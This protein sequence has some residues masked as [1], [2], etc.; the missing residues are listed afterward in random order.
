MHRI[1]TRLVSTVLAL[2]SVATSSVLAL[3]PAADAR[4]QGKPI[5][6]YT[7]KKIVTMD[8]GWPEG[9]CVAVQ[10]GKI[11]SVGRTMDD[12]KPWLDAKGAGKVDIDETFR[13]EVLVPGFIEAHGHPLMGGMLYRMPLLAYLPTMNPYG[14]EIPGITTMDAVNKTIKD[15]LAT[16][17]DKTQTVIFWG[18][19]V[20][21][22]GR[23]LTAADLDAVTGDIPVMVWD[24]SEHFVYANTAAMKKAGVTADALKINGVQAGA[25]GKPNGQFLGVTAGTFILIPQLA[26]LMAPDPAQAA[27][28]HLM[29]MGWKN[30]VTTTSELA[31][32]TLGV[33]SGIASFERFFNDPAVP[34]RCVVVSDAVS[35]LAEKK[36]GAIEF[37]KSL[38][39]RSTDKLIY[40]GVKFFADDAF[41][42]LGMQMVNPG[43][44]DR[45]QGLWITQPGKPLVDSYRPWW[46]AGL[47]LHTHANGNAGNQAVVDALA[48]LQ[49]IKPRFDH[50]FTIQHYG[51]STPEQSRRLAALGGMASV[52]PY[53]LYTRAELNAPLVGTDRAATAARF[54]TL[55]DAGV[56]TAMHTDSPVAPPKPLEEMWIA[57]NR[58]GYFS[59]QVL[60][61]GE[62]VTAMQAMK[63]VTID[64]AWT[65]GIEDKVG[66][67]APGKFA[68]FTVLSEDPLAVAPTAIRDIRVWGTVLNG[69]KF[70]AS[71]IKPLAMVPNVERVADA[72]PEQAS[73]WL[74][75]F[76]QSA[77]GS[78]GGTFASRFGRPGALFDVN[79]IAAH[80]DQC[81]MGFW[82]SAGPLLARA[83]E[84]Q[85][86]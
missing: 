14:P 62:R 50:R 38:E 74:A 73:A 11:L 48:A 20:V 43:Y 77:P 59:K 3:Q 45:R 47:H 63:M 30:G 84:L 66:S 33:D 41:L 53:Y 49:E 9:T 42:S 35:M 13:D 60:A 6:V 57:V 71:D 32:G 78:A 61:P 25:D 79:A 22:M 44:T 81:T 56:V 5:T 19:D 21:A 2:V 65:L 23:H 29:D 37:V 10:D 64:A 68:D 12:L 82:R 39:Q 18:Y 72:T 15:H 67:I 51:M 46:E 7:A 24:A 55:V 34:M 58:V 31:L 54:R 8:P 52:N 16:V 70:P 85:S 17:N 28:K 36:D 80:A 86:R 27:M 40:R 76:T 69:R 83:K 1:C 26:P 4:V 75:V